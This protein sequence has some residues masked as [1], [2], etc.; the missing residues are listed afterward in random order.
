MIGGSY[1]LELTLSFVIIINLFNFTYY[2]FP[3]PSLNYIVRISKQIYHL[4]IHIQANIHSYIILLE[5][6]HYFTF[7]LSFNYIIKSITTILF[8]SSEFSKIIS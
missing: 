6:H 4:H 8:W 7:T 5:N 3:N 2:L 1:D